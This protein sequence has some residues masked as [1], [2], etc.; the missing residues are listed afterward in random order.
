[1]NC[2]KCQQP[3]PELRLKALPGTKTCI[4]CSSSE[5]VAGFPVIT[6]K[7]AYSEIQI[8]SQDTAQ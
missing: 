2:I 6:N 4:N 7:T 1:M 8:V 5:K 3:I